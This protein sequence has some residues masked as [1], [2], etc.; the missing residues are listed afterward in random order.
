MA[1]VIVV[2]I[3]SVSGYSNSAAPVKLFDIPGSDWSLGSGRTMH[4]HF[5]VNYIEITGHP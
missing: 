4:K 3:A 5:R 1:V 2:T